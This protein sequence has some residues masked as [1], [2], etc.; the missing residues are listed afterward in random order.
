M[1]KEFPALTPY[2]VEK[3]TFHDVIRLYSDVRAMQIREND[4]EKSK[5]DT[6][7]RRPAGNNWF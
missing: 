5:K 4:G 3:K 1:C 6:I 2:D 7:I